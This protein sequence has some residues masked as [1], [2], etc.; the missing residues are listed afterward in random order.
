MKNLFQS[1]LVNKNIAKFIWQENP[2]YDI[3]YKV[4][5]KAKSILE[6]GLTDKDVEEI[7]GARKDNINSKLSTIK[8]LSPEEQGLFENFLQNEINDSKYEGTIDSKEWNQILN[9]SDTILTRITSTRNY[10]NKKR[11]I[12][13][14]ITDTIED[15]NKKSEVEQKLQKMFDGIEKNIADNH[16]KIDWNDSSKVD[17][18]P[19]Y[20]NIPTSRIDNRG[21]IEK[22]SVQNG[23][24]MEI[25]NKGLNGETAILS[26]EGDV[27]DGDMKFYKSLA[28]SLSSV[29][30]DMKNVDFASLGEL[31]KQEN[32]AKNFKKTENSTETAKSNLDKITENDVS[33]FVNG[34]K[35]GK[36]NWEQGNAKLAELLSIENNQA[37]I[38]KVQNELGIYGSAADGMAGTQT[39]A[40]LYN[41]KGWDKPTVFDNQKT[42]QYLANWEGKIDVSGEEIDNKKIIN[43]EIKNSLAKLNIKENF[44]LGDPKKIQE[45]VKV[46]LTIREGENKATY[47]AIKSG[48]SYE[49]KESWGE[50]SYVD[51]IFSNKTLEKQEA[52]AA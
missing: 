34:F 24:E 23:F 16:D 17:F 29:F 28:T 38:T 4:D 30:G 48:D 46:P 19:K 12:I 49:F 3:D 37:E 13:S 10:L 11:I 41:K 39:F 1:A 15:N 21:N 31:E 7:E 18:I 32:L 2:D 22:V 52:A 35:N 26:L 43:G 33:T 14:S 9:K 20:K 8:N 51:K 27:P 40:R 36:I 6:A 25:D 47:V 42:E 5:T 45:T 50:G 44:K